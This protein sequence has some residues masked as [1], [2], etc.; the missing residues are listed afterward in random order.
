[1]SCVDALPVLHSTEKYN[2]E[3]IFKLLYEA[4]IAI[5]EKINAGVWILHFHSPHYAVEEKYWYELKNI[6]ES[7]IF[8]YDSF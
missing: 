5:I 6:L 3:K 8:P 4:A 1:M 7:D 2:K